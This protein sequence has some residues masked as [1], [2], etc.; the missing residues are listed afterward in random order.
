MPV[1]AVVFDTK[2]SF[3]GWLCIGQYITGCGAV[4]KTLFQKETDK[5]T[6]RDKQ[7][8]GGGAEVGT[9]IEVDEQIIKA[10]LLSSRAFSSRSDAFS[11]RSASSSE[12]SF[13]RASGEVAI[14]HNFSFVR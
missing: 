13:I 8:F 1:I 5:P 12:Q 11:S 14:S 2:Q 3:I 10:A 4:H 7:L 6:L 9:V